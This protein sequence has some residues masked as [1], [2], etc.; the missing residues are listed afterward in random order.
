MPDR[1]ARE[2]HLF[3]PALLIELVCLAGQ[4]VDHTLEPGLVADGR[5]DGHV[6]FVT[7]EVAA[8]EGLGDE[9]EVQVVRVDLEQRRIDG[10][11]DLQLAPTGLRGADIHLD[12]ASVTGTENVV[13]S[14]RRLPVSS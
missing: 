6:Q 1:F 5:L 3:R 10:A 7:D 12:E 8:F 9:V 4:E 2:R 14:S 11:L 13:R